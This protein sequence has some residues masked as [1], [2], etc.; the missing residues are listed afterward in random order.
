MQD[1]YTDGTSTGFANT[2]NTYGYNNILMKD[3][4]LDIALPTKLAIFNI[5]GKVSSAQNTSENIY[6][7]VIGGNYVYDSGRSDR[8]IYTENVQALY[9]SA[10]KAWGKWEAKAGLRGEYTQN[11]AVSMTLKE[12]NKNDYF[13]LFPTAYVQYRLNDDNSFGLTYSRRIDRPSFWVMNPFRQYFTYNSY[14]AGNP[15]LQPSFS[16]NVE[17]NYT[18]KSSY[19][20]TLFTQQV[21]HQVTRM[22]VTDTM[23]NLFYY[24]EAN[25]GNMHNYGISIAA[26]F[27]PTEWWEGN[28]QAFGYYNV[29]S[30]SYYGQ[31][32]RYALAAFSAEMNHSFILNKSK[33]LLAELGCNYTSRQQQEYQLQLGE[34][35]LW[36]GV[37]AL[38]FKKALTLALST[39]DPFRTNFDRYRNLYNGTI[40]NNYYD[41][42]NVQVSVNWKFG[43]RNIKDKREHEMNED[44]KRIK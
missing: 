1:N 15:F 30:S 27:N 44:A 33:T 31:N 4:R 9:A 38:F 42:R 29:F 12:T 14:D 32:V 10:Q 23:N 18:C 22:A 17:L 26:S 16:N 2:N 37:K 7:D 24:T 8:F 13:K 11:T 36:A 40:E 21:Q 3:A 5:G 41:N 28:A 25:A 43:N 35:F 34:F 6:S 20:F 19:T 39:E